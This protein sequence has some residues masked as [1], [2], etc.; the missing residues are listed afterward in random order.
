[1]INLFDVSTVNP[2]ANFGL[3]HAFWHVNLETVVYTWV[4]M[5][6]VVALVTIFNIALRYNH[7]IISFGLL[8]FVKTFKDLVSQTLGF[9]SF[10]HTAFILTLFTFIFLCNSIGIVPGMEE[11]TSDLNTTL[12]LGITSFVYIQINSIRVHGF[13]GYLWEFF[14]PFFFMMPLNIVSE[15]AS[16]MSISFRLFGNIFGGLII[17]KLYYGAIGGVAILEVLGMISGLNLILILFLGL[18]TGVV[19]AFVFS[20]LSLTYL[21]L[22]I[23]T[24][25]EE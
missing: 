6:V 21:A 19:Q 13:L 11:P 14:Q 5:A 24:D 25:E 12:A 18:F 22:A 15:L 8:S 4:I 17:G 23:Q 7:D 3:T 20:I 9:Y 2:F 16:I 1:M 10:A